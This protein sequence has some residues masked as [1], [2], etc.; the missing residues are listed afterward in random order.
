MNAEL[1]SGLLLVAGF[2]LLAIA[3][4]ASACEHLER[5]FAVAWA[6]LLL[7]GVA[8][9]VLGCATMLFGARWVLK[10]II[11][12]SVLGVAQRWPVFGL[13]CGSSVAIG[14]SRRGAPRTRTSALPVDDLC[15]YTK[16]FAKR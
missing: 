7:L 14:E 16:Q 10:F 5:G 3:F 15:R 11:H 8:M 4:I 9:D 2:W 6:A 1:L 12:N 13:L